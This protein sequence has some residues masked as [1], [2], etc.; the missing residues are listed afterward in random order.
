MRAQRNNKP[1]YRERQAQKQRDYYAAHGKYVA[2]RERWLLYGMMFGCEGKSYADDYT[3]G[4]N[5]ENKL[6]FKYGIDLGDYFRM[7]FDQDGEC[8]G[9]HRSLVSGIQVDVDH[10]HETGRVRG[11]LCCDCN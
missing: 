3:P 10:C 7:F 4:R 8:P 11:I 9:C 1:E 6:K 5:R 2:I